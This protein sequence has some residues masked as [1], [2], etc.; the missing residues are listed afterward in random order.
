MTNTWD[1]RFSTQEYVYGKEPNEFVVEATRVIPSGAKVLCIAE[2]EGRNA[3]YLASLG[4]DV[5]AWD[6]A[7]AGL[8][9]TKRLAIE[10]NV[11]VHTELRDLANVRWEEEQWDAIVHI[12]G[13]FSI[14]V[15]NSTLAGIQIALKPGGFYISEL[16]TKEQLQ[17]GTGGPRN[18]AMLIDPKEMLAEFEGYFVTHFHVGEVTREEGELHTGTAH[19]VQSIFK[20]RNEGY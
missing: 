4:Y 7:P 16:Y 20:K 11:V 17:Y 9:K 2:G 8:E 13:H 5:T 12:F 6:Y 19:V 18:V 15:M 3:V 1:E 14:E 10:K